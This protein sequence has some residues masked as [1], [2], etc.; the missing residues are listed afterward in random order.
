MASLLHG[1]LKI[2]LLGEKRPPARL[3]AARVAVAGA[4]AL[5]S[6]PRTRQ[7][8]SGAPALGVVPTRTGCPRSMPLVT[9]PLTRTPEIHRPQT[10]SAISSGRPSCGPMFIPTYTWLR[11]GPWAARVASMFFR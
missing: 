11:G 1:L 5:P 4:S 3:Q 6:A 2:I 9:H 8:A 7:A 10:S